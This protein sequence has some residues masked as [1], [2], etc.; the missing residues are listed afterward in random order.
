MEKLL[1]KYMESP[2]AVMK[3]IGEYDRDTESGRARQTKK[4]RMSDPPEFL[5]EICFMPPEEEDVFKA[6]CGHRFCRECW[7]CYARGKIRDEGCSSLQCMYDKCTVVLTDADLNPLTDSETYKRY[8]SFSCF[9][10]P[11]F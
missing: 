2:S 4:Q 7:S 8:A 10:N 9:T 11:C 3:A 6:R 1:D 5:C